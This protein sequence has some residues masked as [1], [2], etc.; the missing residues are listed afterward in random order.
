M[1]GPPLAR[2]AEWQTRRTQNPL[3]ERACGFESHLGH[4]SLDLS[5][6]SKAKQSRSRDSSPAAA[7]SIEGHGFPP[8]ELWPAA[9]AADDDEDCSTDLETEG[10]S[11]AR[12]LLGDAC[13]L[14]RVATVHGL[15]HK[16]Q[17]DATLRG[18]GRF[19]GLLQN[20]STPARPHDSPSLT[21]VRAAAAPC[22]ASFP[23]GVSARIVDHAGRLKPQ[24]TAGALTELLGWQ[25]GV[26][27]ATMVDG[28]LALTQR[29][30]QVG[31]P[32]G[33]S[34]AK[35]GFTATRT[36]VQRICLRP[37][38]LI[39]MDATAGD[40]L[41]IAAIPDRG[42][43]V[44]VNPTVLAGFAPRHVL[45]LVGVEQPVALAVVADSDAPI[46]PRTSRKEQAR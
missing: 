28:Y 24:L 27:D 19:G 25:D 9:H 12:A 33:R 7:T 23:L 6:T 15:Q 3:S 20:L 41:V 29:P 22:E 13:T 18:L 8:C 44:V 1:M 34:S 32:R 35:V 42:A 4:N 43:L 16:A 10:E 14:Q 45:S 38:H 11:A 46:S 26:L 36:G 31:A 39:Q 17:S 37:A 2:V 5:P 30:E 21:V 40:V